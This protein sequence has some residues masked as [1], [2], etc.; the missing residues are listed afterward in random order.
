MSE[1]AERLATVR[2]AIV[3]AATT[4]GRD[5]SDVDLLAVTKRHPVDTIRDA[6]NLGL[7][8]FGENFAQELVAKRGEI[9]D[10]SVD[11]HF[12]GKLQRNKAKLVVGNV[13]LIHA[14]D[15]VK[16]ANAIAKR[17][18]DAG[19]V[20]RMLIAVNV[21]GEA[22]KSGVAMADAP[23]L[24]DHVRGLPSVRCEGFM[25]MPPLV[26][27]PELNRDHF[28][29]V[30]ALRDRLATDESPLPVLSMGT[31]GDYTVAVQEGA[32]LVRVGTA[33]FGP[34]PYT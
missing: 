17:A 1:L 24:L 9:A 7:R 34:R 6:M 20:Q 27:D 25:A 21:A 26:D 31:S 14:V 11:W 30:T 32:T 29:A 5:P 19:V 8:H 12:I 33:I 23:A 13:D 3:E 2:A 10:D 18:A 16:L 4:A 28:R 22:T 15:S